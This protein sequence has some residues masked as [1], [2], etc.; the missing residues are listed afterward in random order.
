MADWGKPDHR[1]LIEEGLAT[2][3]GDYLVRTESGYQCL[4][5]LWH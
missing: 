4:M 3:E 2:A 1:F 5:N